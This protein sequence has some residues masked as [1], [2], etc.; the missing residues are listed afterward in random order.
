MSAELCNNSALAARGC[1]VQFE[2]CQLAE[3]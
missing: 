2:S 1:C 3:L